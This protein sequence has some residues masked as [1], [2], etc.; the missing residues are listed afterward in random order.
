MVV[1]Q[2]KLGWVSLIG[3]G[4]SYGLDGPGIEFQW[5]KIFCICL[6]WPT[7]PP[8]QW[9]LGLFPRVKRPGCGHDHPPPSSAE[10]KG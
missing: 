6:D 2:I 5:G 3:V 7:Q 8:L 4:T 10:F 1:Q 9:A